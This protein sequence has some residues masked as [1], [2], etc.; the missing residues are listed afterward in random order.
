MF[1]YLALVMECLGIFEFAE[2]HPL[3]R[4]HVALCLEVEGL[5]KVDPSART[6]APHEGCNLE[7][8][9]LLEEG[10]LVRTNFGFALVA[11]AGLRAPLVAHAG[12]A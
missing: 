12:A 7:Q 9:R 1:M 3:A 2:V 10:G 8:L 5:A 6:K 11:D 4:A